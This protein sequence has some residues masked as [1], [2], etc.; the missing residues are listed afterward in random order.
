MQIMRNIPTRFGLA[1]ALTATL[2]LLAVPARSTPIVPTQ[3]DEV[4][5]VL[6]AMTGS[7]AEERRL[8]K[9]LVQRPR[10]P[11]LALGIA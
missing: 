5:E 1:C 2:V 7:R 6:P 4:I 10:D 8:R 9:L 11:A 3:D